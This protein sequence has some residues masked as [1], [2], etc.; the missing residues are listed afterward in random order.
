MR[1]HEMKTTSLRPCLSKVFWLWAASALV[2]LAVADEPA[3]LPKAFIDGTGPGWRAAG[4]I[5]LRER[6]LQA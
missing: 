3:S 1:G 6:E 5:G 2:V 4:G